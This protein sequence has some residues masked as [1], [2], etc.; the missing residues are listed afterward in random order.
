MAAVALV[1]L[2]IAALVNAFAVTSATRAAES[3]AGGRVLELDGPDLNVREYGPVGA[4]TIVLLHGYSASI[5]WW[6][7]VASRLAG[8][9]RVIAIDLVGHGGSE[10][11]GDP[12]QFQPDGQAAA[13]R[14]AL[15][16]LGVRQAVLIGHSMGGSVASV[17]ADRYP[18]VVERVVIS[19]TPADNDLAAMPLLG[20]MVCW[21]LMGPAM[22]HFR[23]V[24]VITGSS[25]QAG[26]AADFP[27][28]Q[29]A[30][31]SLERLTYQG[32]CDSKE[33]T[34]TSVADTLTDLGKPVLVVWG[35]TDVLTPTAANVTRYAAAGLSPRIIPG[36]GH[37]P[38]VEK[39]DEFLSA[40]RDFV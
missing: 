29:F 39:P 14:K 26:F 33:G 37:S 5:Q 36:A 9:R 40:I 28:P 24:P 12:Q 30:Y 34:P 20:K 1:V 15:S 35:E 2:V 3:F 17:L 21:P 27:V 23:R 7:A 19:D 32:V 8:D 10:A 18:E 16:A 6:E 38:M 4:R 31:R 25:L 11:P 13:V 22:D